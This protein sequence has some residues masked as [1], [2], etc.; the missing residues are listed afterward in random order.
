MVV[1]YNVLKERLNPDEFKDDMKCYHFVK[2][3]Y[4]EM[5]M[6]INRGENI[7]KPHGYMKKI[8]GES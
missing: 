4:D 8:L 5:K 3:R 6:R 1:L 2:A 7:K